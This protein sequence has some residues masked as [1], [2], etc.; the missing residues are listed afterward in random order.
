MNLII[1]DHLFYTSFIKSDFE[2]K[3][4]KD[5]NIS[6]NVYQNIEDA[7]LDLK[8]KKFTADYIFLNYKS[9]ILMGFGI[10]PFISQKT[11]FVL[12]G[13][14]NDKITKIK[15]AHSI[16]NLSKRYNLHYIFQNLSINIIDTFIKGSHDPLDFNTYLI[17][18]KKEYHL[19][20]INQIIYLESIGDYLKIVTTNR[21]YV[22]YSTLQ[23][24][25]DQLPD[26]F[27][28]PHRGYLVH[29]NHVL[30]FTDKEIL[31]TN[32]FSIPVT[33]SRYKKVF[34]ILSSLK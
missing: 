5:H 28:R 32:G 1:V 12:L 22:V 15:L 14:E 31:T 29:K 27:F 4:I 23:K 26:I 21:N 25:Q 6:I 34:H 16:N 11:Q 20:K 3:Y 10:I 2:K 24:A 19:L 33:K 8:N 13:N 18:S 30:E 17:Y 9:S 7:L